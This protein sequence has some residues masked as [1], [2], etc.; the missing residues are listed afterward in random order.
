MYEFTR[1]P[2]IWIAF[3]VFIGGTIYKIVT[4]YTQVKKEKVVLPYMDLKYGMR[5]II[6]WVI[7]FG[8]K[9]MRIRPVFTILSF[10][11]HFCL[12]AAPIFLLGHNLLWKEAF[13]ISW[14]CFPEKVT[15]VMAFIVVIIGFFFLLR[16]MV[17]PTLRFIN[18][19]TDYGFILIVL[20][21]FITGIMAYYQIFD[22]ATVMTL[23]IW[24]GAIWLMAIPFTR[25]IH[26]IYFP[27]TRA[28]MGC[29]FGLVRNARDW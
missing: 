12:I 15:N 1:G 18:E 9:N 22:Y 10:I 19:W 16:R 20:L 14:W 26:M 13:E 25:V 6:H 5:S 17:S 24:S 4:A 11:F 27:L 29:E 3:L 28:Y 7:P 8:S 21:P 2:L 23:H